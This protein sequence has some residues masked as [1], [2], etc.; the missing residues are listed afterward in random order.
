[1]DPTCHSLQEAFLFWRKAS[2]NLP[3]EATAPTSRG[4]LCHKRRLPP[5]PHATH[6]AAGFM[7]S[8][9][10]LPPPGPGGQ[11][12]QV[13]LYCPPTPSIPGLWSLSDI[14]GEMTLRRS[15]RTRAGPRGH[16][17]LGFCSGHATCH[18]ARGRQGPVMAAWPEP[19][20]DPS[21]RVPHSP[22]YRPPCPHS[23][24]WGWWRFMPLCRSSHSSVLSCSWLSFR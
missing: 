19:T 20:G 8:G 7:H 9:W 24:S 18:A 4:C 22:S 21:P 11:T 15:C 10:V 17:Y 13:L 23:P 2:P 1:M 6:W 16:P 5:S 12:L 3:W 14:Q